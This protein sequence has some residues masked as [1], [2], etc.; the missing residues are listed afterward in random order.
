MKTI[1]ITG[2]QASGKTRLA[3]AVQN[4]L[5]RRG[6]RAV[7]REEDAESYMQPSRRD[8]ARAEVVISV[9]QEYGQPLIAASEDA[10]LQ[11]LCDANLRSASR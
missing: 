8:I 4:E 3:I 1:T 6:I 9:R 11:R 2:A 10:Q 5:A 7:I